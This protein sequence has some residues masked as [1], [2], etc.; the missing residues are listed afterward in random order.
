MHSTAVVLVIGCMLVLILAPNR[1]PVVFSQRMSMFGRRSI[2]KEAAALNRA[3]V[4]FPF[5]D[6]C[7]W[8]PL[9]RRMPDFVRDRLQKF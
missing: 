3:H 6:E 8:T 9:Y 1:L 4:T 7:L 5:L 2:V